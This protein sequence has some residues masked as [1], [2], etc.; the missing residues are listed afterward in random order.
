MNVFSSS[1]I[2]NIYH[3]SFSTAAVPISATLRGISGYA[4]FFGAAGGL[5]VGTVNA[6]TEFRSTRDPLNHLVGGALT[7]SMM[8]FAKRNLQVGVACAAFTGVGC[9]F[10]DLVGNPGNRSERS[11]TKLRGIIPAKQE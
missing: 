6:M 1:N 9:A 8:G 7:G 11:W 2:L 3:I 10:A 4:F 5:Y